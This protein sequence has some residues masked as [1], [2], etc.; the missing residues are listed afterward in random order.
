MMDKYITNNM[1]DIFF[2]YIYYVLFLVFTDEICNLI[3]CFHFLFIQHNF[4][5]SIPVCTKDNCTEDLALLDL[6]Q[7]GFSWFNLVAEHFLC[8]QR[9]SH[10][11]PTYIASKTSSR[12]LIY[13]CANMHLYV[14]CCGRIVHFMI[15]KKVI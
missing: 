11:K 1:K 13:A 7:I 15:W 3:E 12:L 5:P 10:Y 2:H 4:K 8:N 14:L 6:Q 9:I